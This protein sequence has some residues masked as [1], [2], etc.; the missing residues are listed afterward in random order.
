MSEEN[1]DVIDEN[2]KIFGLTD[3]RMQEIGQI[4]RTPKSRQILQILSTQ[5]LNAKE[6]GKIIDNDDNPR[7]PNLHHHLN[8]MMSVG[9][10]TSRKKLQRKNGHILNYYKAAS[11]IVIVPEEQYEKATKSKTLKNAFKSVFKIVCIGLFAYIPTVFFIS[12]QENIDIKYIDALDA[13]VIFLSLLC[14]GIIFERIC[15]HFKIK[16]PLQMLRFNKY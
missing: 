3:E 12:Q 13:E 4:L 11:Y 14:I 1:N 10:I 5:E 16:N 9:L 2:V 15:V 8:K 6:I 7:L